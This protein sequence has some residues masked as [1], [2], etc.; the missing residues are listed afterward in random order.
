MAAHYD[1]NNQPLTVYL[2]P[3]VYKPIMLFM[4]FLNCT[5]LT[6]MPEEGFEQPVVNVGG[7]GTKPE[8]PPEEHVLDTTKTAILSVVSGGAFWS[9]ACFTSNISTPIT[10]QGLGFVVGDE[11]V[12]ARKGQVAIMDCA[13]QMTG[14][15]PL[16]P[17]YYG[18]LHAD[19]GD[20]MVLTTYGIINRLFLDDNNE[21]DNPRFIPAAMFL[22]DYG[23]KISFSVRNDI[24]KSNIQTQLDSETYTIFDGESAIFMASD[25]GTVKLYGIPNQTALLQ[26]ID[27]YSY[28]RWA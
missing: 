9:G 5:N 19:G 3:G 2:A 4:E 16:N 11:A 23:G 6:F 13:Y 8:K 24:F 20:I 7:G 26:A 25:L 1:F 15:N 21:D 17:G 12:R 28:Q 18:I 22:A 14:H 10:L 27:S